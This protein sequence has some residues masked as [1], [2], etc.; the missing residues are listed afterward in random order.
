M[1]LM[2]VMGLVVSARANLV[3]NAGFEMEG[4]HEKAAQSWE[5]NDTGGYWGSAMRTDWQQCEGNFSGAI[6][7]AFSGADYG[8]WWQNCDVSPGRRYTLSADFYWDN[9][10]QAD[11]FEMRI[12]WY[13]EG[14][15]I[16]VENKKL[17]GIPEARWTRRNIRATA[18]MSADAAH[19]VVDASG[20]GTEGVLYIDNVA[21]EENM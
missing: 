21:F 6:Q 4:S 9:E 2:V 15:K 17:S 20:L 5:D 8:G 11:V 14:R 18:P 13:S 10:W 3:D 12:E 1:G 19:I 7:G 16:S